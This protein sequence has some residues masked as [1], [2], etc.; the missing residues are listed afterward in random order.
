[1][2]ERAR[3]AGPPRL[4]PPPSSRPGAGGEFERLIEIL[5]GL[6]SAE[7]CPWDR[8]QTLRT[9]APYVLEEAAE[10]VDAIERD[11]V[12]GLREEIGDLVFEGVFLAQLTAEAKQFTIEESIRLA[13]EKLIRRHPH[14]FAQP[15]PPGASTSAIETPQ[16]V[17]AQ[18]AD[19]K[20][21]EKAAKD[22]SPAHLL[23]RVPAALPALAGAN[24]IGRQ[25]A[26]VGF[27]WPTSIEA[28]EKVR[29][30]I[31]ELR[32]EL[33]TDDDAHARAA[34]V[35][36]R[37]EEEIG[38]LLFALAQVARKA[39]ID[40]ERALRAANR[41]FRARFAALEDLARED[42]VDDLSTLTLDQQE[43]IW[44]RVKGRE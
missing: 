10:V 34:D 8:E 27:D 3:D 21:Q 43:A 35:R 30:E 14:V 9:L 19:I 6:R 25:V 20:A 36:A 33:A 4:Q 24:E 13:C 16:Q 39:E 28:L 23:D 26:K 22:R 15:A 7:G 18:W 32:A 11:D 31:E 42:G 1:M 2:T 41:K 12:G 29:E 37:T 5:R 44:Q 38:D 40:P 17:V